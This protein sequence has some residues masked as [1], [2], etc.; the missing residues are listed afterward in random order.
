MIGDTEVYEL[1]SA[2]DDLHEPTSDSPLWTET[3]WLS[4]GIPERQMQVCV[5][6]WFRK[7]I[8][9]QA[10][11][12]LAWDS[13]GELPWEMLYCEYDYHIPMSDG[14]DLRSAA[15]PNGLTIEC[16]EVQRQYRVGY[17]NED[18]S[19]AVRFVGLMDPLV[20]GHDG[21]PSHIDQPGLVTG[22]LTLRGETIA[23]DGPGMRDR[24]W[25]VRADATRVGYAWG[26]T[27]GGGS[28]LC[29]S[30]PTDGQEK[31][32]DGYLLLDG[33]AARLGEGTRPHGA[34]RRPAGVDPDR[35]D[36]RAGP[37]VAGGGDLP[38]PDRLLR[39]SGHVQLGLGRALGR[40]GD[41]GLGRR[42][43]RLAGQRVEGPPGEAGLRG[44]AADAALL[45]SAGPGGDRW[46]VRAR[47]GSMDR[48][49]DG[50]CNG[51]G[52]CPAL[53]GVQGP[54]VDRVASGPGGGR[55]RFPGMADPAPVVIGVMYPDVWEARPR[56][57]LDE[58]LAVLA[59]IDP[60]IEI[61]DVRYVDSDDLRVRRGADPA[62]DLRSEA[63]PLSDAQRAAFARVEIVVAQDLPYDVGSL[64][65]GL[66]FVQGMGAGVSQLM[67]AGLADAGIRLTTA[68]GVG[69]VSISEFVL[70]RLLQIWKRL[71]EIDAHQRDVS[72]VHAFGREVSGLTIGVVGLGAIGRQ[73]A[74]RSRA[75]GLRVVASR[76][77]YTP[78]QT[79]FDV[80]H[81]YGPGEVRTMV[82][83]CDAVVAAVPES[84]STVGLFDADFFAAMR[85][86][87]I[88]CNVGRGSPVV[89]RDLV[90]ALAS[91]Q[92]GAAVLDVFAEEPLPSSSPL[93]HVPNLY[94]SA[95]C[96]NSADRFWTNLYSLFGENVRHYL[97]GEPLRNEVDPHPR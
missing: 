60:R 65:P 18:I 96:A 74:L 40:R 53:T 35:G 12:V 88:F 50:T 71:P 51:F 30:M 90:G 81:L 20:S 29:L 87:A 41:V 31:V 24:S 67:S 47:S 15:L 19:L 97:A 69:A 28:F 9:M 10:G 77:R 79:D 37:P 62:A 17:V 3:F 76:Q 13:S 14:L 63:P 49:G 2:D 16:T 8:G 59:A 75:F 55:G 72:W 32:V 11:G 73:V 57:E 58:D 94:V 44:G 25:G 52:R 42:P 84:P 39:L 48:K 43:R 4:F 95:H 91:G 56:A 1:T 54:R 6:P 70:A 33:E 92:L 80:D 86:G 89:D 5:Y 68:A 26:T 7:N 45:G 82:A 78:G 27:S 66:R 22:S 38:R 64:A 93:W 34:L 36:R 21:R 85:T 83:D 46:P 23:V 61:L